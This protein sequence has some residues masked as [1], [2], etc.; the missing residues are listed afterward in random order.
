MLYAALTFS[1]DASSPS[2]LKCDPNYSF[3][4]S[5]A[6]GLIFSV[7]YLVRITPSIAYKHIGH[8]TGSHKQ[9]IRHRHL[10][11]VLTLA[12]HNVVQF[13]CCI[14][15]TCYQR[16]LHSLSFRSIPY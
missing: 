16:L 14:L 9:G 10:T 3:V 8:T 11:I 6:T 13:S 15:R 1:I 4:K 5:H 7:Q 2:R 12:D